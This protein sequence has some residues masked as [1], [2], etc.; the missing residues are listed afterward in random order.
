MSDQGDGWHRQD[1]YYCEHETTGARISAANLGDGQWKFSL[2]I[3]GKL[4]GVYSTSDE[5]KRAHKEHRDDEKIHADDAI[6]R[7]RA[8]LV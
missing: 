6:R 4:I 7:L 3:S 5:A 8:R 2:W 1:K